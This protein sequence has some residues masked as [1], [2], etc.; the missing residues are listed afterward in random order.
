MKTPIIRRHSKAKKTTKVYQKLRK[1]SPQTINN[2]SIEL[3]QQP[4]ESS[5]V[6]VISHDLTLEQ[7]SLIRSYQ[8]HLSTV[9]KNPKTNEP[10]R[11]CNQSQN[12]L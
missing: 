10:R 11:I 12:K 3:E 9:V 6:A 4:Q 8:M 5:N 2:L 7:C 1:K